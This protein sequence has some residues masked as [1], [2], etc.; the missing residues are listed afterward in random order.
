MANPHGTPIWYELVTADPDAAKRFY[1][2]AIGW[3]I[4]AAP[5]MPGMDYRMI[6]TQ[7]GDNAGGV[8]RLDDAMKAGGAKPAWLFYIGVD[9]VDATVEKAKAAGAGVIMP[10]WTIEGIGRMALLHDPQGIPFYVMRGASPEDSTA[11][12]RMSLGKCN[13]NELITDDQQGALD[14][15]AEVF[16]W[17]YPDKMPMGPMGDSVFVYVV[18]TRIGAIMQRPADAPPQNWRFYFRS[19]DIEVAAEKVK[20]GGGTVLHGPHEVPGGDRI[21]VIN[22]PE[23][24]N[25]GVV[26][27]GK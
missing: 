9:D 21:I 14:F 11:F 4:D 24:V 16:G 10:A 17:E 26:G 3:T 13:W 20:A 5:A 2:S 12:D 25:V 15:Y 8:M 23:G 19:P 6:V 1:D 7:G 27:P 22:D 18:G